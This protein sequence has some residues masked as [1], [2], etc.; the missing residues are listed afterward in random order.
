MCELGDRLMNVS[1]SGLS[2]LSEKMAYPKEASPLS[3]WIIDEVHETYHRS[4][5]MCFKFYEA[6]HVCRRRAFT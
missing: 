3:F 2:G 4:V 1:D 5:E 6:D